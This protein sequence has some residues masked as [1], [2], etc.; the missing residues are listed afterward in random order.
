MV[1]SGVIAGQRVW[2]MLLDSGAYRTI[3]HSWRVLETAIGRK[4]MTFKPFTRQ[5]RHLRSANLTLALD[6]NTLDLEVAVK[7][8]LEYDVLLEV[9]VPFLWSQMKAEQARAGDGD[10]HQG[11]IAGVRQDDETT[12]GA[13]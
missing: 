6:N 8:D 10:P 2:N 11:T 4:T 13:G 12:G 5:P 9:D 7:D 3:V 1:C